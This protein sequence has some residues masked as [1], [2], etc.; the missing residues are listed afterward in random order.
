LPFRN[1]YVDGGYVTAPTGVFDVISFNVDDESILTKGQ[2]SW[3]DT[4]GTM[5]IGLT[6]NTTIH[7]GEHRYFRIRNQTGGVLYKGQVVYATG[8]HSNGLITPSKYVADGSVR[9]VR[10]M[11]LVLENVNNNNNGYVVDFGHLQDM[12]LDGSASN[13]AVGDETWVAGDILYVHP[14]VAGKL[15]KVEPKHSISVAIVLDPGNGNGNG[16][17]FVRPTSYGHL[18]DNHDVD[19]SGLLN[20][21]F[22]VYDSVSDYWQPSSGL[23]YVD[24]DL[25]IGTPTPSNKLHVTDDTR[26]SN[27]VIGSGAYGADTNYEGLTNL[28]FPDQ[29]EDYMIISNGQHT[30][31]SSAG[32]T[33]IRASGNDSGHQLLVTPSATYLRSDDNYLSMLNSSTILNEYNNNVDLQVKG[34]NDDNVLYVDANNDKVGIGTA[35][36]TDKLTV[37]PAN[38][39]TDLTAITMRRN[40]SWGGSYGNKY[41]SQT[42]KDSVNTVAAIGARYD[43]T[44]VNL[45]FHSMYNGTHKTS[46]DVVMSIHGDGNV[47]IGTASPS[48]KLHVVGTGNSV[49]TGILHVNDP[50]SGGTTT[51]IKLSA[52]STYDPDLIWHIAYSDTSMSRDLQ[53][54]TSFSSLSEV[55]IEPSGYLY[56]GSDKS[57]YT[58][59]YKASDNLTSYNTAAQPAFTWTNDDDNGMF[60]PTA[61]NIAFSTDGLERLRIDSYG[62]VGIRMASP[63]SFNASFNQLVIGGGSAYQGATIYSTVQGTLAFGDTATNAVDGYRGYLAYIHN[64][65]YMLIGTAGAERVRITAAGN[66]GIG[67]ASPKAKLD[68]NGTVEFDDL[69]RWEYPDKLLDSN[70]ETL[71]YM[72]LY[73]EIGAGAGICGMGVSTSSFN[74]GTSGA[75]NLRFVTNAAERIIVDYNGNVGIGAASPSEKLDIR[76]PAGGGMA[77]IKDSDNGL[78]F[79]DMAYSANNGYQGIKHVAMTGIYD[80][81]I[82]SQGIDTLMSAKSNGIVYIRGGGNYVTNEIR[83]YPDTR[84]IV[85]NENG[86]DSDFRVEGSGDPN[87]L[88]TDASTDRVGIGTASP[89]YKLDVAGSGHFDDNISVGLDPLTNNFGL[90]IYKDKPHIIQRLSDPSGVIING[91]WYGNDEVRFATIAHYGPEYSGNSAFNIGPSG[92]AFASYV[93]DIGIGTLSNDSL[94]FGT[95]NIERA[96]IN[97]FGNFGIGTDNPSAKLN[98]ENGNVVFNDL[99]GNYDFR[100]EGD[101]D[102]NVLVIDASSDKVGIGGYP[103]NGK[104]TIDFTNTNDSAKDA[105]YIENI[106]NSTSNGN[107]QNAGIDLLARKI[108]NSGV[109]DVGQIIGL[110]AVATLDGDGHL[111]N[112][113]GARTWGGIYLNQSGTLAFAWGIQPRVINAG[114][115]GSLISDARGIDILID[116]DLRDNISSDGITNAKALYIRPIANATNKYGIYQEGSSDDNY[117]A[118]DIGLGVTSPSARLDINSNKLRLRTAKTPSSSSDTGNA[119]DICWDSNY[120]YVCVA[121]NTWKRSSLSTW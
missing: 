85:V 102:P 5:D 109:T 69:V 94:I 95:Y 105:I 88:F 66:V 12:D 24:G 59:R 3:D 91:N 9:E 55:S 121:T 82:L 97:P 92:S 8:V 79:G 71:G 33:Y 50:S 77:L 38:D 110:D 39:T 112:A 54:R 45:D 13:Y 117:F 72:R 119:G 61:N 106:C 75:I 28:S 41:L 20:N 87:L 16:R 11:G 83:V 23:Y 81:M 36:P 100:V 101:S 73:D 34:E 7:I 57:I 65:D 47:G 2:I 99:G 49:D 10:F 108:V 51:W 1:L 114:Y 68:V 25:G 78:L 18:N 113:Y 67:T 31:V 74:V 22:L 107:Y 118:G 104:L 120:I 29:S 64:T 84:G 93:A 103:D 27:I 89:S 46:S 80:Y 35:S 37:E 26:V 32:N 19:T 62:N 30:L 43:G 40:S 116:G 115:E 70:V 56:V 17:M 58:N 52:N 14:T 21:Q 111:N 86:A 48:T 98:V 4:E 60:L 76:Y 96:R 15:T 53:F 42:W 44:S 6:D 90:E 63:S